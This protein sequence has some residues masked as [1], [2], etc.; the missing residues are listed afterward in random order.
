MKKVAV[1]TFSYSQ[2]MGTLLQAY[3]L[4]EY[5]EKQGFVCDLVMYRKFDRK[6]FE[7]IKGIPDAMDT[8]LHIFSG[9]KKIG[10]I[11]KFR[12]EYL[13]FTPGVYES[14]EDMQVLNRNYDI[15][16]AGSD[17]IW[18][19]HKGIVKPYFL[20]FAEK[21]KKKIAYSASFGLSTLP[22]QY[23]EEV[24]TYLEAFDAVS[25]R[26]QTGMKIAADLA[27]RDYTRTIDPVFLKPR[28]EWESL[29]E[30]R[31]ISEDYIF[32]YPTQITELLQETVIRAKQELGCK[33]YSLFYFKG[34]D[35]SLKDADPID[36]INYIRY[37]KL[38]I[39]SS[40]HA[41]A[42]S[43]IFEKNLR[44]IPH[45][46]TGSRVVDLLTEIH[47]PQCLVKEGSQC[48][49]SDIAYDEAK[50]L[51]QE[52]TKVSEEFLQTALADGAKA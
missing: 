41:T 15:F 4:K 5:I 18:N 1:M 39:A 24:K 30:V 25:I 22:A 42:F 19:V 6:P 3:A 32:V 23:R 48:D 52:M 34:V 29:C 47:L 26:E 13:S 9:I 49:F 38:V 2:N 50:P 12:R 7:T 35:K 14:A 17:Q 51:L 31:K 43:L 40:F 16:V 21:E 27:P 45:N 11:D 10:K 28:Q 8:A 33:V 37:A 20:T 36:F 46:Q 44:V